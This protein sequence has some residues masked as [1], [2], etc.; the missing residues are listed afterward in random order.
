MKNNPEKKEIKNSD[1]K[2]IAGGYVT[3]DEYSNVSCMPWHVVDDANGAVKGVYSTK[4]EAERM[5]RKKK[6]SSDEIDIGAAGAL[7]N[8]GYGKNKH[9]VGFNIG[10]SADNME[11]L[12]N[13]CNK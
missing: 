4:E 6:L 2:D 13:M 5:A 3:Y 10:V 9:G 12:K 11:D 7:R 8:S 1:L